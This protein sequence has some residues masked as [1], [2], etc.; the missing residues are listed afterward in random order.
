MS[1][2][3]ESTSEPQREWHVGMPWPN[4][5]GSVVRFQADGD[6]LFWL[7]G[8]IKRDREEMAERLKLVEERSKQIEKGMDK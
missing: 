4:I 2:F 8:L 5:T 3:I 1:L 6:E 7:L